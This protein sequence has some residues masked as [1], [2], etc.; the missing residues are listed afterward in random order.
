M[1][2][3]GTNTNGGNEKSEWTEANS[4]LQCRRLTHK[5][6]YVLDE[7]I[8][9][10]NGLQ[11]RLLT[12]KNEYSLGEPI[13]VDFE[14]R[15]TSEKTI[16]VYQGY[17]TEVTT[18]FDI[19]DRNGKKVDYRGYISGLGLRFP[20]VLPGTNTQGGRTGHYKCGKSFDL[21]TEY[22]ILKPGRYKVT[23]TYC[24]GQRDPVYPMVETKG[25]E[26]WSGV[27]TSKTIEI[28][29]VEPVK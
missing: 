10:V 12:H 19:R 3:C 22:A 5:N 21:A 11:C 8:I 4:G 16:L 18:S 9:A 20:T 26:V 13:I 24:A 28:N 23:A 29:I 6:D 17:D 15:N 7:R 14:L 1:I 2:Q 25:I 27:W